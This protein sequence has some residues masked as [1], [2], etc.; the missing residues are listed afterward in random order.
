MFATVGAALAA[1]ATLRAQGRR[2]GIAVVIGNS[3]YDWETSLPNVKRDAADVAKRFHALGL[4]T[5][6]LEDL[7]G[8]AMKGALAK[9][10][11]SSR[12]ADLAVFYFAGHGVYW[13]DKTYLVPVDGD[14]GNPAMAK[15]LIATDAVGFS[16]PMGNRQNASAS[17]TSGCSTRTGRF[18]SI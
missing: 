11:E 12:G 5:E 14:L 3:K 7:R 1:P 9:L 17:T 10:S 4:K 8:D 16:T 2:N 15:T 6:L 18:R 13:E